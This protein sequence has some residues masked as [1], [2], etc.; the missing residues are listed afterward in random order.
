LGAIL[1]IKDKVFG[2]NS[3]EK[4]REHVLAL[5]QSTSTTATALVETCDD[6]LEKAAEP[7]TEDQRND[8]GVMRK[9]SQ[10]LLA[11]ANEACQAM[12]DNTYSLMTDERFYE[13]LVCLLHD[14][15]TPVNMIMG[16]TQ[17]DL[18]GISGSL[19]ERQQGRMKHMQALCRKLISAFAEI[20]SQ[21]E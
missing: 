12:S 5:C 1:H 6:L 4:L 8:I 15:R 9:S 10:K 11:L 20:R 19:N 21:I 3:V 13:Y 14:L 17:V 7:L 2:M 16:F 18:E